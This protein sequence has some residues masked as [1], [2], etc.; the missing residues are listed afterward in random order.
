MR[1]VRDVVFVLDAFF[2]EPE[3]V[4]P[5]PGTAPE[6]TLQLQLKLKPAEFQRK[7]AAWLRGDYVYN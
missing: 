7:A 1:G 3:L 4:N 2:L 6:A 5:P